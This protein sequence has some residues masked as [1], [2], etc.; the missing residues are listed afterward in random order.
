[1]TTPDVART[2]ALAGFS[3]MSFA[4]LC[5][6]AVWQMAYSD[7]P[8]PLKAPDTFPSTGR[9]P[10][11]ESA[12]IE[13]LLL[14]IEA[15]SKTIAQV[16]TSLHS[17]IDTEIRYLTER[18][19]NWNR[20]QPQQLTLTPIE[21]AGISSIIWVSMWAVGAAILHHN[22]SILSKGYIAFV[23]KMILLT[24]LGAN[25]GLVVTLVFGPSM[26]W[27]AYVLYF[28]WPVQATLGWKV[29]TTKK[30]V[31]GVGKGE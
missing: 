18:G 31:G 12:Q 4:S 13:A 30:E 26:R 7:R 24:L 11:F 19:G 10:A 6:Q 16:N 2:Q 27:Y 23:P 1:M 8:E 5:F 3:L 29:F 9:G 21:I 28:V 14:K 17:K 20:A 15:L 22:A 25:L